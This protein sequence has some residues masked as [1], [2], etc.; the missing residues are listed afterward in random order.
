MK[1]MDNYTLVK[2]GELP[3]KRNGGFAASQ[4]TE[5]SYIQSS[6]FTYTFASEIPTEGTSLH[7][8]LAW[9]SVVHHSRRCGTS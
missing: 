4:C 7:G 9:E 6:V 1:K 8:M 3:I 2:E 5:P